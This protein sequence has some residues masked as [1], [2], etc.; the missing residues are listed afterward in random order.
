M[1]SLMSQLAAIDIPITEAYAIA[2]LL[3]SLNESYDALI[4][5]L[6]NLPTIKLDTTI[7]AES[8]HQ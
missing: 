7:Q 2:V 4:T 6:T 3:A 5:T 1:K 8:S